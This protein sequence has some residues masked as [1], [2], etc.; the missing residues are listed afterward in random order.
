MHSFRPG[1]GKSWAH[2]RTIK[3]KEERTSADGIVH[4]SASEMRR[5]LQLRLLESQGV[6]RNLQRQIKFDMIV[7][8]RPIRTPSGRVKT[9]TLDF[10]YERQ[11]EAGEWVTIYNE[12][13]G[14]MLPLDA[15]KIAVF[16]A[17]LG[18]EVLVTK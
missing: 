14:Y 9:Y 15:F 4:D 11:N 1:K 12:H 10:M 17:M 16:E 13:K 6:V 5:W 7:N 18:V 8:N 3:P 2:Q